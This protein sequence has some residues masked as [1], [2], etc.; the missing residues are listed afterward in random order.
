MSLSCLSVWSFG[1]VVW[2]MM[3]QKEPFE[4]VDGQIAGMNILQGRTLPIPASCPSELEALLVSCWERTPA[5]RPT[6]QRCYEVLYD[7]HAA[8]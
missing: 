6:F 4:G 3:T 2:E 8:L 7:M 1:V 5:E